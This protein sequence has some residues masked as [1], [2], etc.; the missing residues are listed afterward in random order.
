[1]N[2]KNIV[3]N[4]IPIALATVGIPSNTHPGIVASFRLR[5]FKGME[6]VPVD[7]VNWITGGFVHRAAT[8]RHKF[9]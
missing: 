4:P 8:K 3:Q 1:M 9:L 2:L 6:S 7:Y 5:P